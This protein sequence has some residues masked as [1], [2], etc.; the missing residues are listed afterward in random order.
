MKPRDLLRAGSMWAAIL[1]A[2]SSLFKAPASYPTRRSPR[3]N[4]SQVPPAIASGSR[5]P[6]CAARPS[7]TPGWAAHSAGTCRSAE[8]VAAHH[9]HIRADPQQS[10]LQSDIAPCMPPRP[11]GML[12]RNT[13]YLRNKRNE[14]I[15]GVMEVGLVLELTRSQVLEISRQVSAVREVAPTAGELLEQLVTEVKGC[16]IRIEV[17]ELPRR[18][19]YLTTAQVAEMFQVSERAVRKWC[20][21][22]RIRAEQPG[23]PDGD[24]R[25]PEDQF[26]AT[27]EGMTRLQRTAAEIADRYGGPDVSFE[28]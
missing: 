20:Q 5:W 18:P 15:V 9:A 10:R 17:R 6:C 28:R 23:G 3:C 4:V 12:V 7:G 1:R 27:H 19:R 2:V 8:V 13:R 24:W 11:P 21:R 25:I 16:G 14:A 26:A 22:G